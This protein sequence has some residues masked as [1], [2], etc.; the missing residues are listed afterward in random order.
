MGWGQKPVLI[1][2]QTKGGLT[3]E[4]CKQLWG[5]SDCKNGYR[6]V[7]HDIWNAIISVDEPS[8][9]AEAVQLTNSAPSS[10]RSSLTGLFQAEFSFPGEDS[11]PEVVLAY[12]YG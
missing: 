9:R 11:G 10:R 5:D 4:E 2:E 7:R 8:S 1:M 12:R 6:K 3:P